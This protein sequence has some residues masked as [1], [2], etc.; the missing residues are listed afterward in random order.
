M[1]SEEDRTPL[2]PGPVYDYSFT[3]GGEPP[4]FLISSGSRLQKLYSRQVW[5][6]G[7]KLFSSSLSLLLGRKLSPG[8]SR[9]RILCSECP[10]PR[11]GGE[12]HAK[13]GGSMPPEAEKQGPLPPLTALLIKRS[14]LKKACHCLQHSSRAV[15]WR[16]YPGRE[17]GHK[18]RAPKVPLR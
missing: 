1:C 3:P 14:P 12:S 18:K 13:R 16:S 10:H 2:S 9:S 11:R 5:P 8:H 7:L 4:A 17:A 15:A 6:I